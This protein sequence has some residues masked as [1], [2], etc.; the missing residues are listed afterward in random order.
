L[1]KDQF[2]IEPVTD[3]AGLF[4]ELRF[5]RFQMSKGRLGAAFLKAQHDIWDRVT[6]SHLSELYHRLVSP[7]RRL[8]RGR[9][10]IIAPHGALHHLP[11]HALL[12]PDRYLIDDF[13]IS[14]SPSASIFGLCAERPSSDS[15]E[16]LVFGI[17]D[18]HT[19]EITNEVCEIAKIVPHSRLFLGPQA[20]TKRLFE[21]GPKSRIIHLATHGLFR[22]DNPLFSAIQL[23][24]SRVS[25]LDLYDFRMPADLITLS[26]CSTGMNEVVG[27]DELIGLVRGL[28][29]AGARSLLVSLWEV[30]DESTACFMKGFYAAL[31]AGANKAVSLRT[32]MLNTR[33]S[34]PHPYHWAPFVLVGCNSN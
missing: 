21:Y 33:E 22:R 15:I 28:L 29:Y 30:H 3:T 27:G 6:R 8:L 17:P 14:Y 16:S 26:G 13:T 31:M 24:D 7:I 2:T 19:P 11:F 1:N 25:L 23:G 10:L 4:D 20:T 12:G 18:S 32:A 34:F 5:F 9:H